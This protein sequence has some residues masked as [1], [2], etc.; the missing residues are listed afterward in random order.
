MSE[1]S[2]ACA[3]GLIG[4]EDSE[5]AWTDFYHKIIRSPVINSS[6]FF[7]FDLQKKKTLNLT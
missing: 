7:F 6:R 3:A 4:W 1:A 2:H 5:S